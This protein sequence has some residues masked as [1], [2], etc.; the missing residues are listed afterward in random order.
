MTHNQ[1]CARRVERKGKHNRHMQIL[2]CA[3]GA[4]RLQRCRSPTGALNIETTKTRTCQ[5]SNFARRSTTYS[6]RDRR[7]AIDLT[8]NKAIHRQKNFEGST[9]NRTLDKCHQ[10]DGKC[11]FLKGILTL[12]K[13]LVTAD[14]P[15]VWSPCD[16]VSF[17]P[18]YLPWG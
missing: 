10:E 2:P 18:F 5:I 14:A 13:T 8:R 12:C 15:P 6:S 7:T 4:D 1:N 11:S 17:S 9:A 16:Y 3:Q